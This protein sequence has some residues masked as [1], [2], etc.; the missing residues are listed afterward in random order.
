MRQPSTS[1]RRPAWPSGWS[2]RAP[3]KRDIDRITAMIN[4]RAQS[5]TGADAVTRD[6]V[7][8]WWSET[9]RTIE[10]DFRIVLDGRGDVAGFATAAGVG[11]PHARIASSA[12]VHPRYDNRADLWDWLLTWVVERA[13]QFVPLAA[14]EL[15]VAVDTQ[16]AG[17]D[18][19]RCA[20]VDRAGFELVRVTNRMRI[21]LETPVPAAE[22]PSGI[23]ARAADI[24]RDLEAI[25]R[26][27][28]EAWRDHWGFVERPF[29]QVLAEWR[30]D[31]DRL[32]D[33]MAPGL[34]FLALEGSDVVG[35]CLGQDRV[36]DDRTRG[37]ADGFG[38]RPAWRKRGIG[39]ALLRHTFAEFQR[40]G[41]RSVELDMDSRNLTG[42]LRVYERAGMHVLR[43]ALRYEKVLRPGVDLATR[44]LGS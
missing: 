13:S 42:A 1:P 33:R 9:W 10:T 19:P 7:E 15:R 28:L 27:Y 16:F 2:E 32:G 29:D 21:D 37:Y 17:E 18:K 14:P 23:S 26:L 38:V 5:L 31:M 12:S 40:R 4:A 43:R 34:S 44:E 22:W 6:D 3:Q 25:V 24:G 35:M 11:A 8:G 41:Y 30:E 20:A 36:V 39:L